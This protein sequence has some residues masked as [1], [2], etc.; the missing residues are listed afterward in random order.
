MI[1]QYR[2]KEAVNW[3]RYTKKSS[4]YAV[5]RDMADNVLRCL[6]ELGI[7]RNKLKKAMKTHED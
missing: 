4:N 5:E 7:V 6:K 3:M 1:E 2:L